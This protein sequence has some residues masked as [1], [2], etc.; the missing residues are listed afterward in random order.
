MN[1]E[2]TIEQLAEEEIRQVVVFPQ[3]INSGDLQEIFMRG[4][5]LA[6]E[7][8]RQAIKEMR[9]QGDRA[10]KYKLNRIS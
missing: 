10:F 6:K 3:E 5:K 4:Y 1:D 2:K 7:H 9:S 8:A